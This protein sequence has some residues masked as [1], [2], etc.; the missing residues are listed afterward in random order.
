MYVNYTYN[1][2]E[3]KKINKRNIIRSQ[4]NMN[5]YGSYTYKQHKINYLYYI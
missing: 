1:V 5:T 2:D 3:R 4:H